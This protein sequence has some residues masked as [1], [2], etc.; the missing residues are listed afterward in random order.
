MRRVEIDHVARRARVEA[1]ALWQDVATAAA[2]YGLAGLAGSSADVG[3]VGYTLGG[4]IGWLARKYG[5]ACNSVVAV[6][7]VTAD[8]THVRT[9]A[10]HDRDLFWAVRGGGGSFGIVTALEF[11]LYPVRTV[12]AGTLFWP[13]EHASEVLLAWSQWVEDVPDELTSVGRLLRLPP[14][15]EIPKPLRGG[16]YVALEAAFLGSEADGIELLRPLRELDPEFDTFRTIPTSALSALHMDPDEPVPGL[17]DGMQLADLPT[18]AI[19]ALVLTAGANSDSP[20]LSVELRQL[21]GELARTSTGS[22]VL[23]RLDAAF[24]LYAVGIPVDAELGALITHHI[25]LLRQ[26]LAPWEADLT[27]FNFTERRVEAA[28]LYRADSARRLRELKAQ[29]D[30][31]ELF[32]VSHPITPAPAGDSRQV[33]D[34]N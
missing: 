7:L 24:V 22:G 16:S 26:A 33:A 13:M 25:G 2:E 17:G 4:G 15:P 30:P 29:Y 14:I 10:E 5:L 23:D 28:E 12:Y 1:G 18:E 34:A 19:E 31:A 8:G 9:D 27:Y 3:V 21:G 6:E 32:R 20:L 11:S